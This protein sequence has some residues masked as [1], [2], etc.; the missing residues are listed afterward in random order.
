MIRTMNSLGNFCMNA[1][2]T[3]VALYKP[4]YKHLGIKTLWSLNPQSA[5]TTWNYKRESQS[6]DGVGTTS[7]ALGRNSL[8]A[9][10]SLS[11]KVDPESRKQWQLNHSETDLLTWEQLSKLLD[12]RSRALEIVGCRQSNQ[13]N[14]PQNVQR[15]EKRIQSTTV[16]NKSCQHCSEDQK[17]NS[18]PQFKATSVTNRHHVVIGEILLW[19]S[20]S[21]SP[22][23][24][25]PVKV[26]LPRMQD[27]TPHAAP[28]NPK[29]FRS[30]TS[31]W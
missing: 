11:E 16:F 30:T 19:L 21:W 4:T 17:V 10:H 29:T 6:L 8:S 31:R 5:K 2:R 24:Q 20:P 25:L 7:G 15:P 9:I 13:V 22:F 28:S 12:T 1:M 27:E 3:N 23:E 14:P 26:L 18:C